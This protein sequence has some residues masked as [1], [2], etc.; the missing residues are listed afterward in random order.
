MAGLLKVAVAKH[1]KLT[2]I[3]RLMM[4]IKIGE[5]REVGESFDRKPLLHFHKVYDEWTLMIRREVENHVVSYREM[6]NEEKLV[7]ISVGLALILNI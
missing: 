5:F 4:L 2:K 6:Y 7:F 3:R 1:T